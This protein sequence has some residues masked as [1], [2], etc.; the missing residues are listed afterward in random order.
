MVVVGAHTPG[1]SCIYMLVC[2]TRPV[3]PESS[4]VPGRLPKPTRHPISF[5]FLRRTHKYR[6]M[7]ILFFFFHHIHKCS[8]FGPFFFHY[9]AAHLKS[10]PSDDESESETFVF[11]R[12]RGLV[13]DKSIFLCCPTLFK[14]RVRF[15]PDDASVEEEEEEEEEVDTEGLATLAGGF[16]EGGPITTSTS[17]FCYASAAFFLLFLLIM[18]SSSE[19]NVPL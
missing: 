1:E 4:W 2:P 6:S 18:R 9:P 19:D 11:R 3:T 8:S 12:F 7:G 16:A 13:H 17:S 15:A 14:G 5:F 10:S